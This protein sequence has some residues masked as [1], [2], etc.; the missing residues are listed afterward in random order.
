MIA[1]DP[2]IHVS[3]EYYARSSGLIPAHSQTLAKGPTQFIEGIA[4][5]YVD[6]GKHGRVVDVDSNEYVDLVMGVGPLSLGYAYEPVDRAIRDQLEKGI[7]FSLVHPLEVQVAELIREVVPGADMVRYSKSGADVTSAAVRLARAHTGRNRI[8]CCGYHGWHDWY[9][10]TTS[11]NAGVPEATSALTTTFPYGDID[12]FAE[13]LTD[14]VAC[15]IME[16]V[17]FEPPPE[18]Y[19]AEIRALTKKNGTLL[20]FDEMWT[21][22]RLALG[23]AQEYFDVK[24]DLAVFSKAI[25]NGMPIS[26]LCGREDV[27]RRLDEEVFF[28]TTFGGEALSLAATKAT[29]QE[30]RKHSVPQKI[31]ATGFAL[32]EGLDGLI[33]KNGLGDVMACIGMDARTLVTFDAKAGDP[34]LQKS[35]VQQEMIRRGV[36]WAGFH[37]VCFTHTEADVRKVLEAYREVLPLL[38]TAIDEGDIASKLRGNPVQAVFRKTK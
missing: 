35:Y 36:L 3:N 19:L 38:K 18:G 29:I 26:V 6:R 11:R 12:A 4:P 17:I 37:T 15:V 22:F 1:N 21:G 13:K 14:D 10:G 34:L 32:R 7:T 31:A 24:A 16:P 30:L 23:G 25:A 9:V 2:T 20:I 5:K 33:E 8:L 27:M 28:F